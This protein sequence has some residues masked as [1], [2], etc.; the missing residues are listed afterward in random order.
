ML[1]HCIRSLVLIKL[2]V[3]NGKY[4]VGWYLM[5]V[6]CVLVALARGPLLGATNHGLPQWKDFAGLV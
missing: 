4:L 2:T 3:V 5:G 1:E 6:T